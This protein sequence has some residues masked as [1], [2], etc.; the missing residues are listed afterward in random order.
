MQIY[1][2]L[3]DYDEHSIIVYQAYGKAIALTALQNQRFVPPFFY[4]G[5]CNLVRK[6]KRAI[7]CPKSKYIRLLRL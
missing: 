1:E 3:A 2:I 7:F 5:Y 4:M 6:Q